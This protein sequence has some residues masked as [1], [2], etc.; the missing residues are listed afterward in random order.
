[1]ATIKGRALWQLSVS[2]KEQAVE[3]AVAELLSS[4]FGQ[5][6]SSYTD[7]ETGRTIVSIYLE[8]KPEWSRV[9]RQALTT[10]LKAIE[11]LGRHRS[12]SCR[13]TRLQPR[14]WAEAWKRHFKPLQI[15][16]KL[17]IQPSWS[18]RRPKRGQLSVVL[19]PGMSFGTG[20]HPT[21]AFC[22][23]ALVRSRRSGREQSFLDVGTGSGI[24]AICAAKLGYHP[25]RAVDVDEQ[26]IL[27]A[28]S[29]ARANGVSKSIRFEC[30][31]LSSLESSGASPYSVVCAN[32][33]AD[34]LLSQRER[35][36]S[37][38]ATGGIIVVAGILRREFQQIRDAYEATG[39][40]LLSSRAQKEWRSGCFL[41]QF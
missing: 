10:A 15:G 1:M 3:E 27:I 14:D 16:S 8:R 20:Q 13:L 6:A 12:V 34:L 19:D 35:L 40:R 5:P 18:R 11:L 22:L 30:R 39:L 4:R 38:V 41:R 24:L 32:L 23:T 9:A 28:R 37:L 7:F 25:V 26:A 36:I 31:D 21:T 33:L 29:N 2:L 17:L